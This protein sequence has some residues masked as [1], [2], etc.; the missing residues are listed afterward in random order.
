MQRFMKAIGVIIL[1][2][3]SFFTAECLNAQTYN[4]HGY[5]DLGLPSGTLWAS[6]NVG[7]QHPWEGGDYFAWGETKTKANFNW[8]N[9]KY[10][11]GGKDKLTKYNQNPQDGY[12]GYTDKRTK[13]QPS[14]DAAT[15]NW[16]KG[17]CMPTKEQWEE[18]IQCTKRHYWAEIVEGVYG[19]IFVGHN[20]KVLFLPAAG[21]SGYLVGSVGNYWSSSHFCHENAY[22][23]WF[24]SPDMSSIFTEPTLRDLVPRCSG[25]SV[26][27]VRSA[28]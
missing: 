9:Y 23:L 21:D 5:V 6:S 18:L 25:G 15:A 20:G 1:M 19:M 12:N 22:Q 3:I 2:M 17:W 26:R 7:A 4:G 10:C 28:R 11:K 13:L 14:D 24:H 8:E 16:G 27:P